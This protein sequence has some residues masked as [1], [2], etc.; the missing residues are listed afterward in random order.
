MKE[1]VI[2]L[3]DRPVQRCAGVAIAIA[4]KQY[5]YFLIY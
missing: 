3:S 5:Q 1:K 4:F 2:S